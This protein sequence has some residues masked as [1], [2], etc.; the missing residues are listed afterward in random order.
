MLSIPLFTTI[1]RKDK[2]ELMVLSNTKLKLFLQDLAL[3]SWC[4]REQRHS[5]WIHAD[6]EHH[7]TDSA[8]M[9]IYAYHRGVRKFSGFNVTLNMLKKYAQI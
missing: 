4:L 9:S 3:K 1:L 7:Q 2:L 6:H 8:S 5:L